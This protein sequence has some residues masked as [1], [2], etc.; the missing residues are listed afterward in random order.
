MTCARIVDHTVHDAIEPGP[1][2][3]LPSAADVDAVLAFGRRVA[4]D[5]AGPDAHLLVHCHMGISRSTAAMTA[6]LAETRPDEAE[7]A[8]L[9]RVT[10]IRPQ[11]WPNVRMVEF[12][13]AALGRS[14]RLTAAVGRLYGRRLAAQPAL[15]ATM[16][17]L[18]RGREVALGR[19]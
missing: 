12:A 10:A 9:D 1:G 11:A 14:G 13:D 8:V 6:I 2:V 7:D 17:R 3:L 15:A 18:D 5:P 4:S 19:R 16:E